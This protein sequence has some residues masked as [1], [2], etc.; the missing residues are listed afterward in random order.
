MRM[1]DEVRRAH[2]D[3]RLDRQRFDQ[4][5]GERVPKLRP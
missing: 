1:T 2:S 4:R 5:R 3:D